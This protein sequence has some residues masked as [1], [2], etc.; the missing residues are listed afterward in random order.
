MQWEGLQPNEVTFVAL[1]KACSSIAAKEQGKLLHDQVIERGLDIEPFIGSSL[2]DMYGKYGNMKDARTLFDRLPYKDLVAW[3]TLIAGYAH[4][5]QG[6]EA[7]Q[8]FQ[9]MRQRGKEP[10]RVTFIS[11]IQAPTSIVAL[12]HG[13]MIH[14]HIIDKGHESDFHIGSTLVD[15][16]ANC[17]SLEDAHMLLQRLPI[18]TVVTWSTMIV[19]C[20]LSLGCHAR[21]VEEAWQHLKSI[22]KDHN[23]EPT[24]EHYNSMVDI[25]GRAGLFKEA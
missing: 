14:G 16:Y 11:L 8:L 4:N 25:L 17:R 3:S 19:C 5:R 23:L 12:K 18:R 2:I 6:E 9:G 10:D 7:L 21:Y 13:K 1:F 24:L 20:A 22:R 15:M